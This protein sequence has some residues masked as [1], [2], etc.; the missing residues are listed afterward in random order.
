MYANEN[1][2]AGS[3]LHQIIREPIGT[4]VQVAIANRFLATITAVA[5]GVT[6]A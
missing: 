1:L 2:G 5:S 4:S 3:A 6:I